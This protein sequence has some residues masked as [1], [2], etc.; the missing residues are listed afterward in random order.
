MERP[1]IEFTRWPFDDD[2][3]HF[4]VQASN[5]LYVAGQEFYGSPAD[6]ERF[7]R[8]LAAF[9]RH[10]TDEARFEAGESDLR[11]AH[12]LVL[13]A[14]LHDAAGHAAL[15]FQCRNGA[16]DPWRREAR[17]TILCEVASL[18]R[19]GAALIAWGCQEGVTVREELLG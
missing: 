8:A 4:S 1:W 10:P 17:F 16:E 13:R 19:L 6:I 2:A 14:Y 15:L 18:N 3:G 5:G 7:G 11:G 12:W 9:P